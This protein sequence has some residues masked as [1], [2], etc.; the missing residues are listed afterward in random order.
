MP[1]RFEFRHVAQLGGGAEETGLNI[2]GIPY[3]R[4]FRKVACPGAPGPQSRNEIGHSPTD[5]MGLQPRIFK[6]EAGSGEV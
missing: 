4:G 5:Q 2:L 1:L 6:P 3:R